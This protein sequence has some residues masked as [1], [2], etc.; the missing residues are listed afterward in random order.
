V[1]TAIDYRILQNYL[2]VRGFPSDQVTL[3]RA[4][5]EF[6]GP[7]RCREVLGLRMQD[8]DN[9]LGI[10]YHYPSSPDGYATVRWFGKYLGPFG[11]VVDRKA[12]SPTGRPSEPYLSP[13]CDW[14]SYDAGT[15]YICESVLK[16][17]VVSLS[18][19]YAIAG[20]GVWGLC[21]K[22]ELLLP[23]HLRAGTRKVVII[24]DNDW[25]RNANV[26]SAIRR[27]GN[28]IKER[29]PGVEVVHGQI[30]DPPMGGVYWDIERGRDAGKWGVDDAIATLKNELWEAVKEVEIEPTERELALDEFNDKY[31][32]CAHPPCVIAQESGHKYSRADFVGLLEAHRR[33]WDSDKPIEVS[34]LWLTYEDRTYVER[35]DYVPGGE[36]ITKEYY[37]EWRDDGVAARD[38][39]ISPFLKVYENAIPDAGVRGL[40]FRSMAWMLQNRGQKLDKSFIFVGRQV[41]T[42]K[43]LLAKTFGVI[44]GT[45]N[46]ASIGVEDFSSDFNS[47]F[48]AK[49]LVL[50]DDLHRMG[51]KE[52]AKLKRYVTADKIVVNA[53][54][55]K[56]YE[57]KNTAVFIITTNEYAAVAMDDVER[58]NLVVAFD[59]VVHYETGDAW[60]A[61]YVGWLEG[62]GYGIVRSWLEGLDLDGFDPTYMPPMTEVKQKMI[63]M[64]R[65]EVDNNVLDLWRDPDSVLGANKRSVYSTDELWFLMYGVPA[66]PG[67]RI[68]LGRALANKFDQAHEGKLARFF[69]GGGTCR[70]WVIRGRGKKWSLDEA[71][72]DIRV[73]RT[74]Q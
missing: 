32:I 40:L 12:E 45:S 46:Y 34:K 66:Q 71:R 58:R 14:S 4:G 25:K 13:L 73:H 16:A 38:G 62:G 15:L 31:A 29:W 55:I 37:N 43:S 5:I 39:D 44:L 2:R 7:R 8:G 49:E 1:E 24:F 41:G 74:V 50:V 69:E 70:V 35:V 63:A 22:G 17:L 3:S 67:D 60:W 23:E 36:K 9:R 28:R 42:G 72:E 56:Q 27:L 10:I 6:A 11:S 59:P 26:R 51:P 19:R 68:R 54:N 52:V 53:K 33:L 20:S 48:A 30:P 61:D 65:D 18:G 21:A 47:A 57:I 64:G